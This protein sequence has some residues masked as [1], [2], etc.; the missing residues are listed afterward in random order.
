MTQ[1]DFAA[2]E[3]AKTARALL[4]WTTTGSDAPLR[5]ASALRELRLPAGHWAC[6]G[7]A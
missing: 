3:S 2:S 6:I 5:R 7:T 1:D 4:L